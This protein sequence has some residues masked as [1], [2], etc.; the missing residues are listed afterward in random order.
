MSN[1]PIFPQGGDINR[2]NY[3]AGLV[4]DHN[5]VQSGDQQS[6]QVISN[7]SDSNIINRL[8][9]ASSESDIPSAQPQPHTSFPPVLSPQVIDLGPLGGNSPSPSVAHPSVPEGVSD[10]RVGS[11]SFTGQLVDLDHIVNHVLQAI[12]SRLPEPPK[13]AKTDAVGVTPLP[14]PAL[15]VASVPSSTASIVTTS[16]APAVVA[17]ARPV[18]VPSF[19]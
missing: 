5:I 19:F 4:A 8:S 2:T 11:Q 6:H 1:I 10:S 7:E 12:Q 9:H 17:A 16:V 3:N 13:K 14:Q 18:T 15:S